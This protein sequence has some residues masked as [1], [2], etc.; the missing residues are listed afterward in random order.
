MMTALGRHG[1]IGLTAVGDSHE[2]ARSL[3]DRT[4]RSFDRGS[5]RLLWFW[6]PMGALSLP[7]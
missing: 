4:R 2:E 1:I 6:A 5:S 3:F 7:R